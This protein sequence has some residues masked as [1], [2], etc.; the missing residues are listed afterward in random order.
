M[1][2]FLKPTQKELFNLLRKKYS[3]R[4]FVRKGSYILIP[5][6]AP[7]MLLAHLDTVHEKPVK[8]IYKSP[9]GNILMSPQG[10]Q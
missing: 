3:G 2:D 9:D 7:I 1:E 8:H 4:A 5:G 6:E 10:K